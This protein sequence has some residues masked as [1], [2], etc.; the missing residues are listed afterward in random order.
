MNCRIKLIIA[1]IRP[2]KSILIPEKIM[3]SLET[4]PKNTPNK[5]SIANI[6]AIEAIAA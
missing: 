3:F 4:F 6:K 5:K 1:V 2:A